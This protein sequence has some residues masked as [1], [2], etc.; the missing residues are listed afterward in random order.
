MRTSFMV[1]FRFRDASTPIVRWRP[2]AQEILLLYHF[3]TLKFDA[4]PPAR[5]APDCGKSI[6]SRP[7]SW[8]GPSQAGS[9]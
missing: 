9:T 6:I 8:H 7:P 4:T 2:G 3:A 5:A 1:D